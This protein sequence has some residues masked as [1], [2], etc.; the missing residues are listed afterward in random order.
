MSRFRGFGQWVRAV[1]LRSRVEEELNEELH[2][3][4]E[5][6]RERQLASGVAPHEAT[7]QTLLRVGSLEAAKEYVRDERGGRLISDAIADIRIGFRGLRRNRGFAI[8]VVISLAL[9]VAGTTAV[10]SVVHAVLMRSMPYRD[11]E[12]LYF[13]RVWWDSFSAHLSPA[14]IEL[15]RERGG[16]VGPVAAFFFPAHGFS[17]STKSGPEVVQGAFV[18]PDLTQVLG[19]SP[20]LGPGF[21]SRPDAFEVLIGHDLWQRQFGARP[22][23]IGQTLT[24]DARAETVVGVM[25]PGFTVPGL[26][27]GQAWIKGRWAPPTRRGPFFLS[28]VVRL[29]PGLSHEG[30][31]AELT[32]L[33][34]PLMK[35]RFGGNPNWGYGVRSVRDTVVGDSR[36]T[37]LLA[38]GAVGLVLLISILNVANLMLARGTARARE[39]AVRASIGAGRWRLARQVLTESALLG[40]CGGAVGLALAI[41]AP[42]I[43]H[44]SAIAIVPRLHELQMNVPVALFALA[45][46]VAA[47]LLAAAMPVV[48]M[49]WTGLADSLRDGGRLGSGGR[50]QATLRRILVAVEI[51]VALTV[52][53][54]AALLAKTLHRLESTDPGFTPTGRVSF[55]LALPGEQYPIERRRQFLEDLESKL[56]A[57]PGV[58][59][60]TLSSALPPANVASLNNYT[61]EG[62][63]GERGAGVS[64]QIEVSS[65]FFETLAIPI[66]RGRPFTAA[67]RRDTAPVAIVNET[68]ARRQFNTLDVLERR[69]KSGDP[70]SKSAWITIVGV[71]ADVPYSNGVWGGS[72]QTVYT[73][74]AQNL[75]TRSPF[76]VVKSEED[77]GPL[78]GSIREVV[79]GLD[80]SLP[81]RDVA[82]MDQRLR[83][84]TLPARFRTWLAVALAG[85]ALALAVTGIYGVMAYHVTQRHRET[86]IRRA[87]GAREGQIIAEVMSSGLRL[88]G[89][90][91]I[92]GLAGAAAATRSLGTV[93]YQVSTQDPVM[94]LAGAAVLSGA[95]LLACLI[96]AG[97]AARVDPMLVL[98]DE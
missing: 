42:S 69:F 95:A 8:A 54:G 90:G 27:E 93:L 94:L 15:L 49:P 52:L 28:T 56:Q 20:I 83:L 91:V 58:S 30:A 62:Q 75:W 33:I 76:L 48:R 80:P 7:R 89:V 17:L 2:D 44:D 46:G 21:S 68:F 96:P 74:F 85:I 77:A 78:V 87:L 71:A 29:R 9:G 23:V 12:R 45:T 73:P 22:D 24:F 64:E 34:A 82:T 98:R 67:D 19:V 92:V 51:A 31:A 26:P 43:F 72:A 88:A 59:A 41:V 47:G 13:L 81:L 14:D 40:V 86:A 63:T 5:R 61:V 39:F 65:D 18:T 53:T 4:C 11:A 35:E 16:S 66:V 50:H 37:L 32:N 97:R 55:R 1:V 6:E 38:F 70:Q 10:S 79:K 3:H 25:P 60:V 36:R 57:L 84:S